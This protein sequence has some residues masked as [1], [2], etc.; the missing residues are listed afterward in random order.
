MSEGDYLAYQRFLQ[1]QHGGDAIDRT[2]EASL[3]DEQ[4]FKHAGKLDFLDNQMDRSSGTLHA[5][6]SLPNH[7][8]FIAAGQF[9]RLRLPTSAQ[10]PTLLLP[11][12]AIVTDQSRKLV[13]TVTAD[14]TVAPKLVEVGPLQ[15]GLRVINAGL[16][17]S[18]Q[19]IINGLMRARPGTR[20][21]PKSGTIAAATQS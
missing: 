13:M 10:K 2:V 14:G 17:P 7:D 16:T 3:S 11:D 19:V 9:A 1:S 6:A 12:S 5:R 21:T 8:L 15:D 4:D 20:V 18:D